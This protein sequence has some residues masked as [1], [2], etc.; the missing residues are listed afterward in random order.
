MKITK[1]LLRDFM[2]QSAFT[3]HYTLRIIDKKAMLYELT[4]AIGWYKEV[5]VKE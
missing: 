4:R 2:I 1:E 3:N 5:A